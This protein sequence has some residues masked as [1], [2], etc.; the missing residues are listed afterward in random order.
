MTSTAAITL[1]NM[2]ALAARESLGASNAFSIEVVSTA[3]N[4]G[5][6]PIAGRV[7]F[8]VTNYVLPTSGSF[9][10]NQE[11]LMRVSDT[12]EFG[13]VQTPGGVGV[14]KTPL[15][16][17]DGLYVYIWLE[18]DGGVIADPSGRVSVNIN[19]L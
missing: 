11:R 3:P 18:F 5:E 7:R 15:L 19:K 8:A 2:G 4:G 10:T 6:Q 13:Y 14:Y 1:T 16:P 17:A 9:Y 12:V